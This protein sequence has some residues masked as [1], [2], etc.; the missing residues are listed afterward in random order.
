MLAGTSQTAA[1]L[2]ITTF[3]NKMLLPTRVQM[4][5]VIPLLVRWARRAGTIQP[6]QAVVQGNLSLN[7]CLR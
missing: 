7:V 5:G 2:L 6:R 3:A 1:K 4:K